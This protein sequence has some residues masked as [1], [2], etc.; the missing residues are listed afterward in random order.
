MLT[1]SGNQFLTQTD[2]V[3]NYSQ[4]QIIP[5]D[6]KFVFGVKAATDV[7]LA[8]SYTPGNHTHGTYEIIIG[9]ENNTL[10]IIRDVEM[11][12]RILILTFHSRADIN[13]YLFCTFTTK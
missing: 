1:F 13:N 4:V 7:R 9:G 3:L 11:V 2:T 8:L 12:R 10:L 5:R 6:Q